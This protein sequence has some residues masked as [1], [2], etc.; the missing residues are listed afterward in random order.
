M[1][2]SAALCAEA[3]ATRGR[4]WDQEN[5]ADLGKPA[6]ADR[7]GKKAVEHVEIF[8]EGSVAMGDHIMPLGA[9]ALPA[10]GDLHQAKIT[11]LPVGSDDEGAAEMFHLVLV[12]A[13]VRQEG[14]ELEHGVIGIRVSPLRGHRAFHVDEDESIGLRFGD[15]GIEASILL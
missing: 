3:A 10:D 9:V 8:N 12:I 1:K 11:R 5:D 4:I 14:P 7:Q 13:F 2:N 15:A 6:A